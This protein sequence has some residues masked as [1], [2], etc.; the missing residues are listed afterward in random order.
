M[1]R[2]AID[3]SNSS[4]S[5]STRWPRGLLDDAR[6]RSNEEKEEKVKKAV[7]EKEVLG[8]ELRYTQ[9]VVAS[10]LAGWQDL[11]ERMGR[12]AIKEFVKGMV[13]KERAALDGMT[14]ILRGLKKPIETHP[15]FSLDNAD[16][17]RSLGMSATEKQ[18]TMETSLANGARVATGS[19]TPSPIDG[20]AV[21]GASG[22][23][24]SL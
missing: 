13:V 6:Q 1:S 22:Q 16:L 24:A 7:E 9:Q 14:R 23:G 11:H 12:Q 8:R 5:R 21:G 17:K 3:R 4:L 15:V 10:E 20:R 19:G 2:K 18:A